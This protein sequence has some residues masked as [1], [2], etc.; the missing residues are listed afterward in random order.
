MFGR[1]S[2]ALQLEGCFSGTRTSRPMFG[3]ASGKSKLLQ[4]HDDAD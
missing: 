4:T 3:R 2:G 1:A